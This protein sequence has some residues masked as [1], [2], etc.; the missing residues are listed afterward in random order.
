MQSS[1]YIVL[2]GGFKAA[3]IR[4]HRITESTTHT[5]YQSRTETTKFEDNI[6]RL[7]SMPYPV[8]EEGA[9]QERMVGRWMV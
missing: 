7:V 8:S 5:T 6:E 2:S 3:E 4:I 1:M 9:H